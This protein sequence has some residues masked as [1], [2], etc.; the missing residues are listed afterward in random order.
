MAPIRTGN[1]PKTRMGGTLTLRHP[2][3]SSALEN[4]DFDNSHIAEACR[5]GNAILRDKLA[6]NENLVADCSALVA[7]PGWLPSSLGSVPL[8]KG[9]QHETCARPSRKA[10]AH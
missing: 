2:L 5:F 4:G 8:G 3:F 6:F 9:A 7:C 10:A 1:T